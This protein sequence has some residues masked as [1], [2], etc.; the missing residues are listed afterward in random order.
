MSHQGLKNVSDD[1]LEQELTKGMEGTSTLIER[2]GGID[3]I[4]FKEIEKEDIN[5][6]DI[7]RFDEKYDKNW[8]IVMVNYGK[9]IEQ[10]DTNEKPGSN[11]GFYFLKKVDGEY[12]IVSSDG[13]RID[14]L[15]K[16]GKESKYVQTKKN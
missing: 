6:Y 13:G 10:I 16:K 1:E 12:Y 7:K 9:F 3:K 5:E 14:G 2:V 8:T 11:I 4:E 15:V